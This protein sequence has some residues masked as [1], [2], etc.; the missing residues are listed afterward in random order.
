MICWVLGWLSPKK[1]RNYSFNNEEW[2]GADGEIASAW[3]RLRIDRGS[4]YRSTVAQARDGRAEVRKNANR[5]T[6][7]SFGV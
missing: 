2:I 1:I 7:E 5:P 3:Y 4:K 6:V